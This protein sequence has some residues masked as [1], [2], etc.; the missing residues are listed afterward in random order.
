MYWLPPNYEATKPAPVIIS[1]HGVRQSPTKQA[2]LDQFANPRFNTEYI[3]VY[4]QA[5]TPPG[6]HEVM[7]QGPRKATEDDITFTMDIIDELENYFCVDTE[8]IYASGKSEGGG[9]V[10]ML[11]CNETSSARIAAFAP[12]SGAF[13]PGTNKGESDKCKDPPKI[14]CSPSRCN[15]PFLEMHG[16]ADFLA[17]LDG[18]LQRHECLPD[19][20]TY[21]EEWAVRDGLN[22][23]PVS[24]YNLS[25]VAE[26]Y[27]YDEEGLVTWIY[28]GPRVGHD[29]PWTVV[30]PDTIRGHD[31]PASFNATP[32]IIDWFSRFTLP[33]T[34]GCNSTNSTS[35]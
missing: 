5:I 8:R 27:E 9:F 32:F 1:Y 4:P 13:Y 18:G 17:P 20:K 34:D 15:I 16:G 14:K 2:N 6:E 24:T 31:S 30:N 25:T 19:I 33:D 22:S 29:W 12:V 23:T 26:V 21:M 35:S 11:A 3:A 10:G 28:D 7:W